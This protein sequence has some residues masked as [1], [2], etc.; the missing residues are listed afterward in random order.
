MSI[1]PPPSEKPCTR[2]QV[3][4]PLESFGWVVKIRKGERKRYQDSWCGGCRIEYKRLA[5]QRLKA[6]AAR[7]RRLA[8]NA[9]ARAAKMA[10]DKAYYE[11]NKHRR[12]ADA[13]TWLDGRLKT[14]YGLS[15]AD[16]EAMRARQQARCAICGR[17]ER[18][19]ARRLAVDHDHQT[20]KVRDL[21]CHH[22][23]TGLGNFD[24]NPDLLEAAIAY[25]ARHG[26]VRKIPA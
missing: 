7:R 15:L 22:C 2:C 23:N 3:S 8:T 20:A 9:T 21:L 4:Y 10:R 18:T 1:C 5:A 14:K 24:D 17:E 16:Y 13:D 11:A 25:L 19:K 26:V 12:P 6:N